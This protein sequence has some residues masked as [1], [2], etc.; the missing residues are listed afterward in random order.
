[1]SAGW[2]D[3]DL[4]VSF[5]TQLN[6]LKAHVEVLCQP[7]YHCRGLVPTSQRDDGDGHSHVGSI[8]FAVKEW[9]TEICF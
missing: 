4:R 6:S 2:Q 9:Q 3:I 1:M 7:G 8:L 5:E